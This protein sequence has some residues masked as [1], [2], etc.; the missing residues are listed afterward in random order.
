[1]EDFCA[2]HQE[3]LIVVSDSYDAFVTSSPGRAA[4]VCKE[5]DI[6]ISLEPFCGKNCGGEWKTPGRYLN[7]GV[8]AGRGRALQ[9]AYSHVKEHE[10]DQLGWFSFV[11]LTDMHVE[12]D[13]ESALAL[14]VV[15]LSGKEWSAEY[16]L[17]A[18]NYFIQPSSFRVLEE[19][20]SVV[21]SSQAPV[22]VHCPDTL[23]DR[24]HRYVAV[25]K[26]VLG[27]SFLHAHLIPTFRQLGW[28]AWLIFAILV[29]AFL[30]WFAP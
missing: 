13:T 16:I 24:N 29:I 5:K 30:R 28:I 3:E 22:V 2:T 12:A 21:K 7:A 18:C 26:A 20:E 8:V 10:D 1:M 11:S 15:P 23:A 19:I 14:N 4:E 27:E 6:L 9:A 25:G 17:S